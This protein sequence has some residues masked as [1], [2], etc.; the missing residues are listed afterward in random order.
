MNKKL[1]LRFLSLAIILSLLINIPVISDAKSTIKLNKTSV[2]LTIGSTITLKV[3]NT[4]KK[5][6]WSSNKKSVAEVDSDGEVFANKAGK[7]NITAKVGK[8]KYTCKVVVLRQYISNETII[9]NSGESQTLKVFGISKDD[10]ITWGSDDENIAI[11]SDDGKV[12]ALKSGETTIYA[13]LNGGVGETYECKVI[14]TGDNI[15]TPPTQEPIATPKPQETARPTETPSNNYSADIVKGARGL[16]AL[17][18]LLRYPD[19][20]IINKI[21]IIQNNIGESAT[22]INYSAKNYY[23]NYVE[24]TLICMEEQNG[25]DKGTGFEYYMHTEDDKWYAF[26]RNRDIVRDDRIVS[27]LKISDV[28]DCANS[29]AGQSWQYWKPKFKNPSWTEDD[30]YFCEVLL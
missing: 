17:H 8:K 6:K 18:F 3:K 25:D 11:V 9:L 4:T 22:F 26:R 23:G 7:A 29:Y 13:M 14:V 28:I 16:N 19:S 27:L 1:Y 20:L 15:L 5:V 10:I 12:T 2:T 24:K 30:P 21:G